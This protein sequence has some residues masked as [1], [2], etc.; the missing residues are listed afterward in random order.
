ME[1][2]LVDE[3]RQKIMEIDSSGETS[4]S[5][6]VADGIIMSRKF[7]SNMDDKRA[8]RY[9]RVK[10]TGRNGYT[11]SVSKYL[12]LGY[13]ELYGTLKGKT[14]GRVRDTAV[15]TIQKGNSR[16]SGGVFKVKPTSPSRFQLQLPLHRKVTVKRKSVNDSWGFTTDSY[17][18]I[19]NVT[20]LSLEAKGIMSQC[21][22][23]Y[24][25]NQITAVDGVEIRDLK[26]CN[27][28]SVYKKCIDDMMKDKTTCT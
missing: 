25:Y 7:T 14:W 18:R 5:D 17:G 24:S 2:K 4:K 19:N 20:D 12:Y 15:K 9:F 6:V 3:F 8:Y 22:A 27:G 21:C 13:W 28:H 10:Q 26:D 23:G 16:L 11:S 1:I